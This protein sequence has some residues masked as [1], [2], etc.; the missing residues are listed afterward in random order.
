MCRVALI[1]R[2][3]MDSMAAVAQYIGQLR[4]L[5]SVSRP[6]FL[7]LPVTLITLGAAASVANT[8]FISVVRTGIALIGLI[9]LHV[10]VNALNEAADYESG[11]DKR[12]DATPFSGGS[13]TLPAGNI[14]PTTVYRFG[15]L[16]AAVGAI[17]GVWFLVIIGPILIPIYIVGGASVLAYTEYLTKFGLGEV[18]AGLGLGGLPVIGAA[19]V[20]SGEIS[21]IELLAAVPAFIL[22]FNLLLLNEFPDISPDRYGG[23][24]N[25]IHRL[26]RVW[27]GRLYAVA[28][29]SVP[30]II[31]IG[32]ISNVFPRTALLALLGIVAAFRPVIWSIQTP[33]QRPPMAVLRNNVI[34]ILSTNVLLAIGLILPII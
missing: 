10:S 2:S 21:S 14:D 31:I 12:T 20:Q 19:L 3:L 7:A 24:A 29:V 34:F 32:V 27:G 28:T 15:Y 25:L 17:I 18:A 23:R 4:P 26:G 11:I 13:K 30:I 9:S 1:H 8:G 16:T 6:P 22:T 5:L 33:K